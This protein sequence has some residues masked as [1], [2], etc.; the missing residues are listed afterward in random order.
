[1]KSLQDS[2][3][4]LMLSFQGGVGRGFR[5][6]AF[7]G[8]ETWFTLNKLF[9]DSCPKKKSTWQFPKLRRSQCR[10][11]DILIL[12]MEALNKAP[13]IFGNPKPYKSLNYNC[14]ITPI[15]LL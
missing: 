11:K 7:W 1:M 5:V 4:S 13:L 15:Y 12:L 14:H 6:Q 3:S 8:L 9:A 2:G 10:P